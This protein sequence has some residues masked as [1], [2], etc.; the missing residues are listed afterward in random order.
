MTR[1]VHMARLR[2]LA[3]ILTDSVFPR[4][5][6]VCGDIVRT[7]GSFICADC[8]REIPFVRDPVCMKCGRTV[9]DPSEE[10]CRDCAGRAKSFEY[11]VA[12][13][14]YDD[15]MQ[16]VIT[17]IKYRNRR[18]YIRPFG[19][20][21]CLKRGEALRAMRADCLVPVPVH[22][23]RL[24]TRG[25][26]QAE[27]LAEEISAGTGIPLRT[28]LLFR[29][30]RTAAQKE[31]SPDERIRNLEGAFS[32]ESLPGGI[33]RVILVDDIYTTGSTA[34]TCTR[35]LKAVGAEKV[36][37]AVLSIVPEE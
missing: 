27:L 17:D 31:L 10:L 24:K 29:T 36:Y 9:S 37:I 14:D 12:L 16:R 8:V 28:D 19:R 20:L 21:F 34:E 33:R 23:S 1:G 3:E 2:G 15:L 32:A 11:G 6:P 35:I 13:T 30:G 5:C 4:R 22:P 26:N 25:F 18:E 7:P